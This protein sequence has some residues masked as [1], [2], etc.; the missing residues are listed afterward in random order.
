MGSAASI[1]S[2]EL[3]IF[4]NEH[5]LA[6]KNKSLLQMAFVHSSF[7]N[8]A[9]ESDD[10]G[11]NE[12]LEFLGDAIL[13]FVVSKSLYAEFPEMSE[14]ELTSLRAALVRRETLAKFARAL[15]LGSYLMLG[16][17][18][19][20]SGGRERVAT[21]HATFEALVG[22]LF[23]DQGIEAVQQFVL[24]LVSQELAS[25]RRRALGK[26]A[27][28]RLQEWAQSRFGVAPKYRVLAADGP[29]H[30]KVFTMQVS[31]SHERCGV[32]QGH[33]KQEASQAAAAAAAISL[34]F[35]IARLYARC[36]A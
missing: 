6:F 3:A 26:D 25:V 22:A 23:L 32:G 24:P 34:R 2:G 21:L 10:L 36:A 19:E 12:R 14:G 28:S 13:S 18:E 27:K 30:A 35:G 16:R 9:T 17:G 11:D 31:I 33:S 8:E 7:V 4:E 1:V 5:G 29:D 20:D 15:R